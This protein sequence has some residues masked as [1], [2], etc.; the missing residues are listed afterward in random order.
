MVDGGDKQKKERKCECMG[1]F[2]ELLK[3]NGELDKEI[4][5]LKEQIK[6]KEEQSEFIKKEVLRIMSIPDKQR[7]NSLYFS[8]VKIKN[9][10]ELALVV[11][12]LI[13]IVESGGVDDL[14][15]N[16]EKIA[17]FYNTGFR[18]GKARKIG[19][20]K[21]ERYSEMK[22]S[23]QFSLDVY[24]GKVAIDDTFIVG[25]LSYLN[26]LYT[27]ITDTSDAKPLIG[28]IIR[29]NGSLFIVQEDHNNMVVMQ[30]LR[31][32]GSVHFTNDVFR[33]GGFEVL[34]QPD[35]Y[36]YTSLTFRAERYDSEKSKCLP[37]GD[38]TYVYFELR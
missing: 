17:Y 11:K 35:E 22:A 28:C 38:G 23:I 27:D 12:H 7:V 19:L 5:Q 20:Y 26:F 31:F 36:K 32:K 3:R 10:K 6:E 29:F 2:K 21:G 30:N 4:Q 13:E 34:L 25:V 15:K 1:N 33:G 18:E 16:K 8:P 24:N 14:I 37:M 9:R